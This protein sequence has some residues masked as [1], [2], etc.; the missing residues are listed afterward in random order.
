M[1]PSSLLRWYPRA[2]RDRY[3]EELLA[4]I[5]DTLDEG[6]PAWR[7]SLGVARAACA[8]EAARPGGPLRRRS[9]AGS[10]LT[11]GARYS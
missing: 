3:G 9:G 2:W 5:Q 10:A 1:K 11:G 4:L 8:N 6:H 7:L